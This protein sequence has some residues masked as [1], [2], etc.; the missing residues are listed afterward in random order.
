MKGRAKATLPD[1]VCPRFHR[2]VELVGRKWSGAIL[3]VLL[4]GPAR[5]GEL[6]D[7]VPEL[8]DRLLSER[9]KELEDEGIVERDV[10]DGRPPCVTYR[11]TD[12]GRA[13]R[14]ALD[15]LGAWAERWIG[16]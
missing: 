12:R 5:F 9:L 2:A 4:K 14:P 3:F 8:S 1:A 10:S 13:L 6:K 15:A 16:K 7:R 11:L